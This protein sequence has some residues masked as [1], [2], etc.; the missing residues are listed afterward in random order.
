MNDLGYQE[1][2]LIGVTFLFTVVLLCVTV[3]LCFVFYKIPSEYGKTLRLTLEKIAL[4][5]LTTILVIIIGTTYLSLFDKLNDGVIAIFSGIAGYVLG[6][7]KSGKNEIAEKEGSTEKDDSA[8][9][10]R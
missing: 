7:V 3:I 8:E 1:Y 4:I 6:T 9:N 2:V 10:N 5:K